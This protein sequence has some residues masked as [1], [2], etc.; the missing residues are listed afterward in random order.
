MGSVV[1]AALKSYMVE[2]RAIVTGG[3]KLQE[4]RDRLLPFVSTPDIRA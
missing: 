1:E 4:K 3:K 2:Y